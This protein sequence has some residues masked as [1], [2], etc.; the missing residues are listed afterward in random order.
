MIITSY[1]LIRIDIGEYS[2]IEFKYCFLDEAQYIKNKASILAKTVK[3]IKAKNRFALTGTPIENSLS[4]L[5]S[6][7]DFI[8]PGYLLSYSKFVKNYEKPIIKDKDSRAV[9][10]LNRHI[11]PFILRRMKKNV[12]KELPDKIEHE[13]LVDMTRKQK[14]VYY[15][16]LKNGRKKIYEN[17]KEKGVNS[18]KFIILGLLTRLRQ[19]CSNPA[20]FIEN[21]SGENSKIDV[22]M[23][24]VID[25]I[26]NGHRILVFS[27]FV[28]VLKIVQDRLNKD[29]ISYMYLDGSTKMKDRVELA[30]RFNMGEGEVF[31]ISLRAGGTG[32]NLVG[33]DIVVHFD[34]WWNPA[35]EEQA[36]DR[37]HRIGQ[38]HNVEI[39]KLIAR[40]TI[41]EKI[42]NLQRK[43]KRI[44]N[45]VVNGVNYTDENVL[46]NLNET[47]IKKI[48]G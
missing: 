7:F 12:V 32:L 17:I 26:A 44:A 6:I 35:V 16:Y 15:S 20:S 40:D 3:K 43:K 10:E 2:D 1:S 14:E 13:I 45:V 18:N 25:G 27:Q 29:G 47:E 22:L 39:I 24:I 5:W 21:Y 8:M 33:A 34:P 37:A 48:L 31:L 28:S 46:L 38:K 23:N 19:I 30:D 4:E 41:E 11:K 9:S 36:S 42:Y